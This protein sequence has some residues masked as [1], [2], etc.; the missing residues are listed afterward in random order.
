MKFKIFDCH[1]V[2]HSVNRYRS[3]QYQKLF[4]IIIQMMFEFT[5]FYSV[6]WTR[7]FY[8]CETK[9]LLSLYYVK[10]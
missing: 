7:L 4:F 10:G 2:C 3:T 9:V 5:S 6:D 8:G 1:R